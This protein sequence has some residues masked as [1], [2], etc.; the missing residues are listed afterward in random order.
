MQEQRLA[1]SSKSSTSK[2]TPGIVEQHG[3]ACCSHAD[4]TC[5]RTPSYRAWVWD[6]RAS[7]DTDGNVRKGQKIFKTFAG[8]ARRPPRSSGA[9][10]R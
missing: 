3:R 4:A 1:A 10:T 5:S 8:K 2:A 6:K 9:P 7:R